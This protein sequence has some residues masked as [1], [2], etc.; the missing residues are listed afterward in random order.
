MNTLYV[1]FRNFLKLFLQKNRSAQLLATTVYNIRDDFSFLWQYYRGK[2]KNLHF[3]KLRSRWQKVYS[4]LSEHQVFN[5]EWK[6]RKK[7][8]AIGNL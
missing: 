7:F 3:T 4:D 1:F 5:E 8:I 6:E 2:I